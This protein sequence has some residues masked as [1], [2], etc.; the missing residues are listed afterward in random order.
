MDRT[1]VLHL[2][3]TPE[4]ANILQ[5]TLQQHTA[6]FNT[7]AHLGFETGCRNSVELHKETY[8]PLRAQYPDLPAQL[9]CAA[10]VK[11]AEAIKSALTWK[12][13]H[14]ARYPKLVAKAI[15]QGRTPPTFKPVRAPHS[16][17]A[18]IRYDARSFWVKWDSLTASLASV[19]G[20]QKIRFTIPKHARKYLRWKVCSA[21]LRE[22][23]GRYF[24]HIVVSQPAPVVDRS[25]DV[26]G[27][28]LGLTRPAVTSTRAFLGEHGWK[29]QER[30]LFRLRRKLQACGSK[31]AKR[32]LKK[33]SGKRFRQRK[34]HDH[35]LSKRLVHSAAP[36]STIVLENL[37]NIRERVSH[38]KG[39]GQRRMHS[40]S[41]AQL[42]RFV[43]YKAEACGVQV[44][45][46]DPRHTSQT[47]SR[48]GYQSRTNRRS[49]R[50][51]LC[52][53]CGY[54]LNA[55][56][57]AAHNIRDKHLAC[58]ASEGTSL[59]GGLPVKQPLVSVLRD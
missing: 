58:L 37:A 51:F 52:R 12:Q 50:L 35:V 3:P 47:C 15:K 59:T 40:W 46:V 32:H 13:K 20:R 56:L 44:A 24:L 42:H 31:S 39:E 38:R 19:A 53:Q 25:E 18:P 41:F 26:I 54:C 1:L 21:D 55:D 36:G 48:C 6:C 33:L 43:A 27:V 30:R 16:R 10:R 7:V 2:T 11:A 28:D 23:Q 8:Y 9:V 29:E 49:Q 14:A 4:Q 5:E 17:S 45:K 57:N 34:D 22:R